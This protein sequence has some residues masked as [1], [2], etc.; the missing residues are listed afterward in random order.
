[1]Y[2]IKTLSKSKTDTS[3]KYYT[4]R[5]MESIRI[6]KKVKKRTILNLGSDFDIEQDK[7][8]ELSGRIDDIIHQ[9]KSLFDLDDELESLAQQYA[10]R[11]I[12]AEGRSSAKSDTQKEEQSEQYKEIDTTTIQNSDPK[13]IG[14]EHLVY[15]TIQSLKLEEKLQS[16]GLKERQIQ[17]AIGTIIAKTAQ[18]ASDAKT[19]RW[20]CSTSAAN[21]LIGCDFNTFSSNNTYRIADTLLEHK[22]ELE[23]HLY[24]RQKELFEYKETITLYDL[25]NTYFE[26]EAKSIPKAKRGRSKEKRSDAPLITLAVILDSSGFV[27]KSEIFEGNI[28]EP[29]TFKTVIEDIK[30]DKKE[31]LLDHHASLVVMD[32]GIAT[33]ENIDYLVD[34]GYTLG[35]CFSPRMR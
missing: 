18:P 5:L 23:A 35:T 28:S 13:T 15:E 33:Q 3:K 25:T 14:I 6:G 21:E 34:N 4:Y 7:W 17:S 19:Y 12:S 32:A 30:P 1:M 20:L 29:S 22:D 11:I 26:G 27:K 24:R 16:L 31:D 10:L 8:A 2:I 9:R